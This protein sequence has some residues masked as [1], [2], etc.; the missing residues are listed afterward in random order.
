[1]K[2]S[3]AVTGRKHRWFYMDRPARLDRMSLRHSL[4]A[5]LVMVVW[6]ANFVVIDEGL[7]DV[8]PLLFLAMRFTLVAL[9]LVFFVPRP[10]ARWQD[11]VAVGAFMSLGQFSLLYVALHLGMPAGL[12]SLILQ[13]QV[14]FTIVIAG[15]VL[16]ERPT[17]RQVTGALI[18]T[19]GLAV[20]VMAHGAVAPVVPLLVMLGAAMSW[21]IGN[22]ISRRAGISSGFSLVVWSA[23][24]VPLPALGLSLIV[25]GGDEVGRALTSLS[26]T[27]LASTAYTALG[28]SLLGYG[29]WNSLLARYPT[30]AVVPFVLLVPVIGIL[31]AWVVQDEVPTALELVGGAVMLVGV[32]AATVSRR[33]R[34]PPPYTVERPPEP[35]PTATAA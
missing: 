33:R 23:L 5:V 21:A 22:V 2:Q 1:M 32:A 9:P 20:V 27:A 24:V 18:G 30:G 16:R 8:P 25:D 7:A 31:A 10:K 19:A 17:R 3:Y 26:A 14:I 35:A 34:R 15:V 6:G 4:L 11:V 29:I 13:A 12:A 28:A